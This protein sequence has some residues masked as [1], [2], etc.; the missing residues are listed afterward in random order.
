MHSRPDPMK[1]L[2][3]VR[4]RDEA[5]A[6][7][8]GGADIIDAK[9]P[10][11][12]ALGSVSVGEFAAIVAAVG[13]AVPVT[14]A[15]GDAD[16]EEAV[17]ARARAFAQAGAA[18]VKVGFAGVAAG[19]RVASMIAA[20]RRGASPIGTAV[21]AV[22]YADHPAIGAPSPDVITSAAATAG[23]EGVLLDTATKD[24]SGLLQLV[25]LEALRT[26]VG[27][28]Q[29]AGMFVAL[30]GQLSASDLALV[31]TLD[32]N[33][34]GVRGAACEGGR[35]GLVSAAQVRRLV[36]AIR[37]QTPRTLS[38]NSSEGSP[39]GRTGQRSLVLLHPKA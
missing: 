16:S 31:R 29:A 35:N 28:L 38:T 17:E 14:A 39:A 6:A 23:A 18:F 26:W 5:L 36:S 30:A 13:G 22:A 37:A 27:R 4:S 20:A 11:A 7:L 10:A 34:V 19:D 12:G 21:V 1:L 8:E 24:G 3:S 15:L 25:G 9:E 32:A 33:V 2:V